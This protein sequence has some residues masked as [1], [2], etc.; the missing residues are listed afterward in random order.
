M[1]FSTMDT[2][3][4]ELLHD[5]CS[6]LLSADIK[7]L[8][9]LNHQ[10]ANLGAEYLLPEVHLVFEE[11]SV[12][13]LHEIA[14]HPI[15]GRAVTSLFYE[16][17]LIDSLDDE[18]WSDV[19]FWGLTEDV[20]PEFPSS[21]MRRSR[22]D[23]EAKGWNAYCALLSWQSNSARNKE[24]YEAI[25]LLPNLKNIHVYMGPMTEYS[26][27]AFAKT[28]VQSKLLPIRLSSLPPAGLQ[29]CQDP[30]TPL[31]PPME[32]EK[33]LSSKTARPR[34]EK[35]ILSSKNARK[36]LITCLNSLHL[37][38]IDVRAFSKYEQPVASAIY[39][40]IHWL[41]D[42]KIT[43]NLDI[44]ECAHDY[45]SQQRMNRRI[46][47]Q[48]DFERFLQ[49]TPNLVTVDIGVILDEIGLGDLR[50]V[51][52]LPRRTWSHLRTIALRDCTVTTDWFVDW[53]SSHKESLE[54]I[55][56]DHFSINGPNTWATFL[57]DIRNVKPWKD[58]SIYGY[59]NDDKEEH[60][61]GKYTNEGTDDEGESRAQKEI[62]NFATRQTSRNPFAEGGAARGLVERQEKGFWV[63]LTEMH[64]ATCHQRKRCT[65]LQAG[66]THRNALWKTTLQIG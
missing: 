41:R 13:R 50:P 17:T 29:A 38:G 26:K 55:T 61:L 62:R 39:A 60:F 20:T 3:P 58:I 40:S 34:R 30:L 53:I 14:R 22:E 54:R 19:V 2:L 7:N 45:N 16:A 25:R 18:V 57:E 51:S 46:I 28:H 37:E 8:R 36:P 32:D 52:F 56:L 27:K 35:N 59:V 64:R 15:I 5:V 66:E 49:H 6:C 24:I 12:K 9:L 4:N 42:L 11:E 65:K 48:G 1:T 33:D 47:G 21:E 31:L 63:G 23:E 10:F 43:F 44:T